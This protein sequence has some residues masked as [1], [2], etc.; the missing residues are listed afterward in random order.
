MWQLQGRSTTL[1]LH[2]GHTTTH[3]IRT[4]SYLLLCTTHSPADQLMRHSS[5]TL[6]LQESAAMEA[7]L[8]NSNQSEP[9][10]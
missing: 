3:V 9:G 1:A 10:P 8:R 5:A 6:L 2:L 4:T 7:P